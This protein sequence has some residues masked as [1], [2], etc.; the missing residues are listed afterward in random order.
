MASSRPLDPSRHESTSAGD[1]LARAT[2][3]VREMV[4]R[5]AMI[6]ELGKRTVSPTCTVGTAART[7]WS[8]A[9]AR[10]A[11]PARRAGRGGLLD[12]AAWLVDQGD[13]R[14]PVR[15]WVLSLPYRARFPRA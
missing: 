3:T 5:Y 1:D 10:D 6:P 12:P 8:R 13:P 14:V 4:T 7:T 9:R 2:D 15:Q 11:A